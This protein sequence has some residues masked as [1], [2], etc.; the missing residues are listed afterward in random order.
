ML[1]VLKGTLEEGIILKPDRSSSDFKADVCVDA[2]FANSWGTEHGSNPD[3]V[4]SC[5]G[6]IIKLMGCRA[7]WCSKLQTCVAQSTMEAEHTA[8]PMAL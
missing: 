1:L 3:F 6:C 4:K 2:E 8:L 5:T 7:I